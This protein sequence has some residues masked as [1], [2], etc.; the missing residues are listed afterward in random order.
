MAL[1]QSTQSQTRKIYARMQFSSPKF[2][3]P[4]KYLLKKSAAMKF[5]RKLKGL[6]RTFDRKNRTSRLKPKRSSNKTRTESKNL[7]GKLM[8]KRDS[9]MSETKKLTTRWTKC[10]CK[11]RLN[12]KSCVTCMKRNCKRKSVSLR[13]KRTRIMSATRSCCTSR[14]NKKRSSG[15]SYPSCT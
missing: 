14:T 7:R 5:S 15:K 4:K 10:R 3:S 2:T 11:E 12:V 8:S 13:R 6:P 9:T 1:L